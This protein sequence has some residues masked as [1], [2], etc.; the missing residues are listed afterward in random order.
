[1]TAE[2]TVT[3]PPARAS[4]SPGPVG[5]VRLGPT[6]AAIFETFVVPR[7][8]SLFGELALEMMVESED[9]QVVHVHCRT[10]YPDRGIAT[11]LRGAYVV[12]ID[13]SHAAI[14]LARAKAATMPELVSQ[15]QRAESLPSTLPGSAFSHALALCPLSQSA[16]RRRV[17]EECARLLA[18]HGQVL[19]AMPVRGS[20]QE[21]LDLLREYSLKH[22]DFAVGRAV[23]Q[24]ALARP[25]LETLGSELMEAGF[26]FVED[27]LRP[28]RLRFE[29]G[30]AF[31]ED[32][33]ARLVILP[34]IRAE[35]G[36]DNPET[37]LAYVREAV[38]K[39]WSDAEFELSVNVGC[40][41]ARR[42]PGSR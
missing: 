4:P 19:V 6:E 22:D 41:T 21:I 23:E 11:R 30:R 16:D 28:A 33:V 42:E 26:D 37:A 2:R 5:R 1:V 8:L 13:E 18:A 31:F 32:P 40:V 27:S 14:E 39:Y 34:E 10:G 36:I 38:D 7:Y 20:F 17:V 24:A 9:A 25:T 15:Y 12:G 3:E 29:S 35:L